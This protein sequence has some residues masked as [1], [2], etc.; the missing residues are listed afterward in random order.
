[1]PTV[2]V[3]KKS[4]LNDANGRPQLYKPGAI[5]EYDGP[6]GSNLKVLDEAAR[7]RLDRD[8]NRRREPAMAELPAR[9]ERLEDAVGQDAID[10][11]AKKRADAEQAEREKAE[12]ERK[13]ADEA[14]AKKRDDDRK[15]KDA[16]TAKAE[17]KAAKEP[18]KD[19][20]IIQPAAATDKPAEPLANAT[21]DEST[22]TK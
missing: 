2:Q 11:A 14:A 20:N 4:W 5:V 6:M 18:A 17:A 1:M 21:V 22:R 8:R 10:A 9:V 12:A 3:V 19:P 7:K 16:A 15:A 13:A